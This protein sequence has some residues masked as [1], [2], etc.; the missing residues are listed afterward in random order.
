MDETITSLEMTSRDQ[1][2]PGRPPPEP[3]ELEEASPADASLCRATWLRIGEPYG[4]HRRAGWSDDRWEENLSQPGLR[5][6]IARVG[7]DV[8]G[9]VI[10][11]ANPGGDVGIDMFG[12]V[13]EFIGKGFGGALLTMATGTAWAM[14]SPDG[15]PV[16]RVWVQTSQIDH[17][18]AIRNYEARGFRAFRTERKT[19]ATA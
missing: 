4:W 8:A 9:L 13:P 12:L 7:N 15:V 18:H 10:L 11:E 2:V 5:A 17:P 3:I 1:L 16:K 19:V 14:R 6:W